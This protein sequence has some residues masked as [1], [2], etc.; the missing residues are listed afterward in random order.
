MKT[1]L[2]AEATWNV[3]RRAVKAARGPSSVAVAYFA[4]SAD[5]LLRL[6]QGSRL[7]VNASIAAVKAGQTHPASLLR[8]VRR[9]KIRV[10]SVENLHAK[11]YVLGDRAFI[12][13]ANASH[14]SAHRLLEAMV[15]TSDPATV[16]CAREFV[17]RLCKEE[18]SPESLLRLQKLYRPP[19][20]EVLPAERRRVARRV[21]ART[22]PLHLSQLTLG[23]WPEEEAEFHD[24]GLHTARARR[25]HNTGWEVQSFRI[26]GRCRIAPRDVVMQVI[27][28]AD[29]T[30][31]IEPP[32]KV[33][34]VARRKTRRGRVAYVY[35]E[36]RKVRRRPR[37]ET[38]A[39]SLGRGAKK[40][41]LRSGLIR[42]EMFADRIQHYWR[43]RTNSAP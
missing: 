25:E 15:S 14:S 33:L 6:P 29:G 40:R 2:V 42:D 37:L 30:K 24:G 8:L 20:V 23:H 26:S 5:D 11:V 13:S 31:F 12:G 3:L 1:D 9:R 28:D 16:R 35:V 7:V 36:L 4:D 34:N 21:R 18:L 43:Q 10:Y 32:G 39:R 27:D 19:R 17:E 22:S 38:L 41:L